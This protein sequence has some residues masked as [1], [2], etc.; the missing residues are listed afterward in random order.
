MNECDHCVSLRC[1][2]SSEKGLKNSGLS[3]GCLSSA[4]KCDDRIRSLLGL[5]EIT[6]LRIL[7]L[8]TLQCLVQFTNISWFL[9]LQLMLLA[10][11]V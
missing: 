6:F 8:A 11:I 7:R 1:L 2:S 5:L 10:K 4:R 9:H 3:C